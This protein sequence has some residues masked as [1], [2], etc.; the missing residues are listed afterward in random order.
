MGKI[1]VHELA[2]ELGKTSNDLIAILDR[3]G[4]ADAKPASGIDESVAARVRER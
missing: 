4:I 2:K 3:M 1:R